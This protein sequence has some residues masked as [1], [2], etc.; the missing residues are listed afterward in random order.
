ML[1]L[2][3]K[4]MK[5]KDIDT[6]IEDLENKIRIINKKIEEENKLNEKRKQ[7]KEL[8]LKY[9]S[10]NYTRKHPIISKFKKIGSQLGRETKQIIKKVNNED[11]LFK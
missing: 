2:K 4:K 9:K 11:N 5:N 3:L 8:I 6:Q 1:V 7:L 10:L